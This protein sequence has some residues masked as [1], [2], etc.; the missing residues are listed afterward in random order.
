MIPKRIIPILLISNQDLIKTKRF[1]FYKYVGD[2]LNAIKIFNEEEVDELI[3][4]DIGVKNNAT[5]DYSYIEKLNNESFIPFTYGGGIKNINDV[6]ILLSK[7]IE[8]ISLQ[9]AALNNIKLIEEIA[10]KYGSQSLILSLDYLNYYD[11]IQIRNKSEKMN[12]NQ[13]ESF[14][15]DY[16]NAGIG[17]LFI[18]NIKKD[19]MKNN[20]DYNFIEKIN[21]FI[22]VPL[23]SAGGTKN[24]NDIVKVFQS[25]ANAVGVGSYFIFYGKF[26]AVLIS[27]PNKKEKE[28]ISNYEI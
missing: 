17:E 10:N 14:L 3:V 12:F 8:K 20:Q 9:T 19:G 4:I 26:D 25:G 1:K 15:K 6:D 7:G 2:P 28:M 21:S 13:L 16:I 23:I 11:Y 24:K 5:P 18:N 27:Y 22:T